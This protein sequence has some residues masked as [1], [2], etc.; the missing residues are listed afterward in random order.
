MSYATLNMCTDMCTLLQTCLMHLQ[1]DA[2]PPGPQGPL[3]ETGYGLPGPKVL[4]DNG[5]IEI[6]HA[7]LDR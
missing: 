7:V 6:V 4:H 2:G 3:G 5:L 1:G